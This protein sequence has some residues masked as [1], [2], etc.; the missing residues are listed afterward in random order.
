MQ[1]GN[2]L[3]ASDDAGI[4]ELGTSVAI[5]H[6]GNTIVTGGSR[7]NGFYGATWIF[8]NSLNGWRQQGSKLVGTGAVNTPYFALQGKKVDISADGN[9][10]V[11][12]APDDDNLNG[13]LW[14]FTRTDT[15]WSQLNSKF[16][17]EGATSWNCKHGSSVAISGNAEIIV[18]GAIFEDGGIG[19]VWVFK[20]S[21]LGNI[22]TIKENDLMLYPNPTKNTINIDLSNKNFTYTEILLQDLTTKKIKT[23]KIN[24]NIREIYTGFK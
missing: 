7:D 9:I 4:A 11:V 16:Y 5:S 10:V 20:D 6:D 13:A 22:E 17:G 1:Q 23:F 14:I 21:I 15:V 3:V 18:E 24:N 8:T 19:A 2:K 12:G